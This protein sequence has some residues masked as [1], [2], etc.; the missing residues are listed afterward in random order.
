MKELCSLMSAL[1]VGVNQLLDCFKSFMAERNSETLQVRTWDAD[2]EMNWQA[3]HSA[4]TNT[5]PPHANFPTDTTRSDPPLAESTTPRTLTVP[6][7]NTHV[8]DSPEATDQ[9]LYTLRRSRETC[10]V[11]VGSVTIE[12][13]E[14]DSASF[15]SDSSASTLGSAYHIEKDGG[16]YGPSNLDASEYANSITDGLF[17]NCASVPDACDRFVAF[18]KAPNFLPPDGQ[19]Y[20]KINTKHEFDFWHRKR[21]GRDPEDEWDEFLPPPTPPSARARSAARVR[22]R[23]KARRRARARARAS[24]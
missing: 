24:S 1:N 3:T 7:S 20:L 13:P 6:T 23:S 5:T 10:A 15:N 9:Q 16:V 12:E 18:L 19:R 2:A 11:P 21:Y 22:Q 4:D 14:I 17:E 8:R